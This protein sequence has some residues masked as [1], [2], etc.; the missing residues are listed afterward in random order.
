MEKQNKYMDTAETTTRSRRLACNTM[1][2]YVRMV[3]MMLVALLTGRLILQ[4]LGV[5]DYGVYN[6]VGGVVA[7]FGFI[8]GSLGSASSR[9]IT[10]A[11]GRGDEADLKREFSCVVGIHYAMAGLVL[12]LAETVGLWFAW[13]KLVIP[14][15]RTEA[16]FWVYQ[17]AVVAS[18][19][20]LASAPYNALIIAH[21]RMRAFACISVFETLARLGVV[22]LLFVLPGDRLVWYA[23][24]T[25]VVQVAVRMVYAG[26]CRRTFAES[27]WR[28]TWDRERMRAIFAYAGWVLNGNLAVVGCTQGLNVLL[29]LFF[30]PLVNAAQGIAMQV[31]TAANQLFAGFQTAANP[32]ITKSYAQGDLD[33]MHRLVLSVSRLSAYLMLVVALPLMWEAP[34]LLRLWLGQVPEHAVDFV[35]I[36]LLV[37]LNTTLVGPTVMAVHA[38]G[39]IRR[40]QLVEG[41]LLLT[42]VPV[43]YVLLRVG[44]VSANQVLLVYLGIEVLTQLVRVW[45]VYP[46]IGLRVAQYYTKVMWPIVKVGVVVWMLPAMAYPWA[47][48]HLP[49]LAACAVVVA[50]C[51]ASTAL[52]TYVLGLNRKERRYVCEVAAG[53]LARWR[54]TDRL[55]GE[56]KE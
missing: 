27:R 55:K 44:H 54:R 9:F 7:L 34:Y 18:V 22:G 21:E 32:Q 30:G 8:E 35:R 50:T 20:M 15:D 19:V 31:L 38:T 33:Y 1:M 37:G 23:L 39:R 28:W 4:A 25:V 52:W 51:V 36:F 47:H 13:Y 53:R 6:V 43:G 5:T 11:L 45:L 26:Y 2:L 56:E 40:F 16:A 46:M 29:N 24:L 49:E 3:L 42:V 12:L 17:G 10:F 48:A 41:T 14:P